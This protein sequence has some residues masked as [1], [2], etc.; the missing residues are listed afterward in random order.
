MT[1]E[2]TVTTPEATTATP[3]ATT[4]T[5]EEEEPEVEDTPEEVKV[6]IDDFVAA[7]EKT[8]CKDFGTTAS[9]GL[10]TQLED[11]ELGEACELELPG[12]YTV[13]IRK[14]LATNWDLIE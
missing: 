14:L 12:G 2:V 4:T 5:P 3:E 9:S 10:V 11:N 7:L 8:T 13:Q 1:P 6:M